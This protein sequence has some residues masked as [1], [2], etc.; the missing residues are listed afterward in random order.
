QLLAPELRQGLAP[1]QQTSISVAEHSYSALA[2]VTVIH[3]RFTIPY[4][5]MGQMSFLGPVD[6]NYRSQIILINIIS[7]VLFMI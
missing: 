6:M 3:H 1:D 4:R 5:G 7:R 2:D